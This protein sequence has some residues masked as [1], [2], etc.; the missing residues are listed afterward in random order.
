[1]RPC[2]TCG[3]PANGTR[4]PTHEQQHQ[5]SRNQRRTWYHGD[6]PARSRAARSAHLAAHGPVCPG[7][8]R[9]AHPVDPSDLQLD[10]TTGRVLCRWCN[11]AAGPD[12]SRPSQDA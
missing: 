1:M 9:P 2:L 6:W 11:V 12:P 7:Y 5:A 8:Q 10:H 3:T 4:C